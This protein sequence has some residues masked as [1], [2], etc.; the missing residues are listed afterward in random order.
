MH[1]ILSLLTGYQA[2]IRFCI[3]LS[4]LFL[5]AI[6]RKQFWDSNREIV[7]VR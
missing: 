2:S 3:Q 1:I 6:N 7:E 4:V 5:E